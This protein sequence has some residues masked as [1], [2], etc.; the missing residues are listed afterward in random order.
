[1]TIAEKIE[2]EEKVIEN[3]DNVEEVCREVVNDEFEKIPS[4]QENKKEHKVDE[5][6]FKLIDSMYK[7]RID[8]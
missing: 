1:M 8:E 3:K 5:D 6:F 2:I 4:R 7:E